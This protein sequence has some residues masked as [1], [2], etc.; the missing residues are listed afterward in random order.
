MLVDPTC[1]LLAAGRGERLRPLT[2]GVPK[3]CLPLLDIPL[4]AWGLEALLS[5][6][7]GPIVVNT[8]YR[9]VQVVARLKPHA[10][11]ARFVIEE[12]HPYGTA[13][14]LAAL[15]G[16]LGDRVLTWNADELTDLDPS[17]LMGAH[18][19]FGAPA[20]LAV[21]PVRAGADL[22]LSGDAAS[23]F[24]DR[25]ARPSS[26]G[27]RYIG[28]AVFDRAVLD[29]LPNRRPLG[30][31]EAL[32]GPMV[33]RG[34]V[35]VHRHGGYALDVGTPERYLQANADLLEGTGPPPPVP[36]PG[37]IRDTEAGRSYLGPGA[38][39]APGT[40]GPGAI[41]LARATVHPG[42]RVAHAV[43]W[44]DEEVPSGAIAERTVWA[45][46]APLV[47]GDG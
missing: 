1:V 41:L 36:L 22:E 18:E 29:L 23:V 43:V 38:R 7:A 17:E 31:A 19:R 8:A 4:A 20:T 21:T 42:A 13:G 44:M 35:A 45:G 26:P 3:P 14:T 46:G 9:A 11:A 15:R 33:A 47:P 10:G 40:L 5:L 12:P 34:E 24:V 25:R 39:A 16:H 6:G 37:A 28:A 32:I 2:D 27:A 30:L